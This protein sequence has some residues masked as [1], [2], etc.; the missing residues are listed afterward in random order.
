VA[1]P[2]ECDHV[3]ADTRVVKRRGDLSEAYPKRLVDWALPMVEGYP[4]SWTVY[5]WWREM[6]R[7][8]HAALGSRDTEASDCAGT[9]QDRL[10]AQGTNEFGSVSIRTFEQG[11]NF[12]RRPDVIRETS[13]HRRGGRVLLAQARVGASV[14]VVH[15]IEGDGVHVILQ[16]L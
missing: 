2:I 9:F 1:V 11:R 4:G 10:I 6:P 14:V 15:E 16:L 7:I 8:L 5:A 13:G 3:N 12:E